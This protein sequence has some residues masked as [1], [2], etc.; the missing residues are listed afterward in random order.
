M[1]RVALV[2]AVASRARRCRRRRSADGAAVDAAKIDDAGRALGA[3]AVD[4]VM[5][6]EEVPVERLER[7]GGIGPK[8]NFQVVGLPDIADIGEVEDLRV[9]GGHALAAHQ[10]GAGLVAVGEGLFDLRPFE[11]GE[12][13]RKGRG[14]LML[15]GSKEQACRRQHAGMRRHGDASDAQFARQRG[16]MERSATAQRQER[17]T[18]GIDAAADRDEPDR[19]RHLGVED[20]MDAERCMFETETER[21]R[22][23]RFDRLAREVR[24]EF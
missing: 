8:R 11:A 13:P 7:V 16:R 21:A 19:F 10:P 4:A 3:V 9:R 23:R 24:R 5:R 17:V 22:D 20:A 14:T 1:S 18:P 12:Q 6:R 15:D 2:C